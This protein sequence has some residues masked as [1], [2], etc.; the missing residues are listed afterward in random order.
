M[1]TRVSISRRLPQPATKPLLALSAVRI[2]ACIL[3]AGTFLVEGFRPSG[4]IVFLL[5][6]AG[7]RLLWDFIQA[8]A[9]VVVTRRETLVFRTLSWASVLVPVVIGTLIYLSKSHWAA[10]AFGIGAMTTCLLVLVSMLSVCALFGW[11]LWKWKPEGGLRRAKWALL[12]ST[13]LVV[14]YAFACISMPFFHESNPDT[15]VL[16]LWADAL[17]PWVLAAGFVG[18]KPEYVA[19]SLRLV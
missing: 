3:F 13:P 4:L 6:V 18:R 14:I 2:L 8:L 12:L 17:F 7:W 16:L 1:G 15:A 9:P 10:V 19:P 11:R 5:T